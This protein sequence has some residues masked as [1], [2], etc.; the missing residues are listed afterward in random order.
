MPH[1]DAT[2][3]CDACDRLRPP[4]I[5]DMACLPWPAPNSQPPRPSRPSLYP[6]LLLL[7]RYYDIMILL[8]FLQWAR[9]EFKDE[10]GQGLLSCCCCL[11]VRSCDRLIPRFLDA[12]GNG[13]TRLF[14]DTR[15]DYLSC[16]WL[17]WEK[18]KEI[19][20]TKSI[21]F[22]NSVLRESFFCQK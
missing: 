11:P 12:S 20:K 18:V 9:K 2:A 19:N 16:L 4:A 13:C 10:L 3:A 1:D 6:R 15:K 17:E 21:S 14:L 8:K 5:S 22:E 7:S